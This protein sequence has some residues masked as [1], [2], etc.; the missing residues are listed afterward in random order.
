MTDLVFISVFN[1]GALEIA[2]NHLES[3]KRNNISNYMAY[4]TDQESYD[5]LASLGYNVEK[6]EHVKYFRRLC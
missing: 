5:Q 4:V 3:L 6:Y 2:T 1:K